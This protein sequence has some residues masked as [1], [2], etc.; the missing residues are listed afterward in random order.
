MRGKIKGKA[1]DAGGMAAWNRD[2]E[3]A[4]VLGSGRTEIGFPAGPPCGGRVRATSLFGELGFGPA[5]RW[6]SAAGRLK[7]LLGKAAG[8]GPGGPA[9]VSGLRGQLSGAGG[10]PGGRFQAN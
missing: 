2:D 7:T 1:C 9:S 4:Y 6:R 10:K 5:K 8:N 3:Y